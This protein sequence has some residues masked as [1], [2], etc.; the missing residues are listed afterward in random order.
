MN[1]LQADDCASRASVT[2]EKGS[3]RRVLV[4][5]D[6]DGDAYLALYTHCPDRPFQQ[7]NAT[8]SDDN[9]GEVR[10]R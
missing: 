5:Y 2:P 7:S 9:N 4:G 3:G 10:R 6:E 8:T 1:P